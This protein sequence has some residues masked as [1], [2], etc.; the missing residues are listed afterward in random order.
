MSSNGVALRG[1]QQPRV[2]H[3]PPA[4]FSHADDAAFFASAYG[5]TPDE[6]QVLVLKG[7]LGE[8]PAG[9]WAAARAGLAVP[10]Q[11]GKN[12]LLEI[13]ELYG[14]V[15]LGEKFLHTAH[16]VKTARKAFRRLAGFFENPREWPELFDLTESIRKTNGQEAIE[17]TN[18]GSVE[19]VARSRGSGRGYTVDVLVCDEAQELTDEQLEALLPTVSSAPR[20]NPQLLFTGT[21]PPPGTSAEVF[22]RTRNDALAAADPRLSWHEWSVDVDGVDVD[23][24]ELWAATNPA[25]GIR[26]GLDVL[27]VERAQMSETG[28]A[29]ERL[30]SWRQAGVEPVIPV[31]TWMA[32]AD[33]MSKA[34]DPVVFSVDVTPDR[35]ACSVGMAGLR[36]D[37][38][39]HVEVVDHRRGTDWVC[40]RMA[41]LVARWHPSAVV[42]DPAGP[43]GS[44]LAD[45]ADAGVAVTTTSAQDMARACGAF[46]DLTASGRLRHIDQPALNSALGA[47][48]KRS[49]GDAW[50]W[51]RRDSTDITPLVAVTLAAF[52]LS[53]PRKVEA[54]VPRR[55]R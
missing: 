28:F 21:P 25:L 39:V 38:L 53:Q 17:L 40:G 43:A 15:A 6:W 34:D 2:S 11:N 24:R 5:L 13:R 42:V 44:L 7:W 4:S 49:L 8:T 45:L 3:V 46:Y 18:G 1:C 29:R 26:L 16:E 31:E 37:R 19:F 47:A 10:R 55:V 12:A 33:P 22:V 23:D 35:D 30:G 27:E 54:F 14:M 20:G 9:K 52:G 36:P 51:H 41:E 32:A 50:A 48:R